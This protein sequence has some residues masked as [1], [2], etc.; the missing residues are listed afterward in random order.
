MRG[1]S[2]EHALGRSSVA[3]LIFHDPL[4]SKVFLSD[5][6]AGIEEEGVPFGLECVAGGS[7]VEMAYAAA[8]GSS[9]DVGVGVDGD[10]NICVQ[11]AK[12]PRDAP[13]L[14]G[15]WKEARR[16]GHNAARLVVGTPL[17]D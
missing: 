3:I 9:V 5:I 16:L 15:R 10:G 7:V 8:Q 17:K 14:M 2:V 13:A 11:H 6:C 12:F 4:V 1:P